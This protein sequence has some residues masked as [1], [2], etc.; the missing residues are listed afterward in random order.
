[1]EQNSSFAKLEAKDFNAREFDEKKKMH[2]SSPAKPNQGW[3]F[4]IQAPATGL[5]ECWTLEF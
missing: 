1:M 2:L 3:G 4:A 5:H